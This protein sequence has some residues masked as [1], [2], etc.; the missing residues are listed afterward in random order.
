MGQSAWNSRLGWP[1]G[2]SC[3]T[4]RS[5]RLSTRPETDIGH[6]DKVT[7]A[8]L[9]GEPD[10]VSRGQSEIAAGLV[11]S[12]KGVRGPAMASSRWRRGADGTGRLRAVERRPLCA[13]G[14]R[15]GPCQ[16][17][18]NEQAISEQVSR[19]IHLTD[20][21]VVSGVSLDRDVSWSRAPS[22]HDECSARASKSAGWKV[23]HW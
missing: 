3:G 19:Q 13:V 4:R 10:H 15:H 9:S 6:C 14:P 22:C 17:I 2:Q 8:V 16:V 1:T 7:S 5:V 18:I 20:G 11:S 12:D 21:R 23:Q